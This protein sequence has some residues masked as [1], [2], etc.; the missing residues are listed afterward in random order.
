MFT[1]N[2][3]SAYF[4]HLEIAKVVV[5]L[6]FCILH[7]EQQVV[8]EIQYRNSTL[9]ASWAEACVVP[10]CR[11]PSLIEVW[12]HGQEGMRPEEA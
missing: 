2:L 12:L 9:A 8:S 3:E 4:S 6:V 5:K 11:N 1:N 10:K 7:F